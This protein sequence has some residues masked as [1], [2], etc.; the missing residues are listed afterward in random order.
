MFREIANKTAK[1]FD[2]T[3]VTTLED[4]ADNERIHKQLGNGFQYTMEHNKPKRRALRTVEAYLDALWVLLLALAIVDADKVTPQPTHEDGTPRIG[5]QFDAPHDMVVI[6]FST[7]KQY[8]SRCKSQT[9]LVG[10]REQLFWLKERDGEERA[11]WAK[12]FRESE[13]ITFGMAIHTVW[14]LRAIFWDPHTTGRRSRPQP[15]LETT[16]TARQPKT[17]KV[18]RRQAPTHPAVTLRPKAKR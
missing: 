5:T 10:D 1:P 2:L 13:G 4:E 18:K 12:V 14:L 9:K 17:K 8:F 6:P 11:K 15:S 7:L 16:R 3:K